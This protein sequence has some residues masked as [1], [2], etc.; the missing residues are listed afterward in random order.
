MTPR[1]AAAAAKIASP[2]RSA[3]AHAFA[4]AGAGNGGGRR[5]LQRGVA[6]LNRCMRFWFFRG[7]APL[8]AGVERF[9]IVA[10]RREAVCI[11]LSGAPPDA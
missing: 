3:G 5:A 9:G 1:C 11:L 6:V 10:R 7:V 4:L 8:R 2:G